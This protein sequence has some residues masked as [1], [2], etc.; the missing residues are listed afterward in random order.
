MGWRVPP[1]S[2][3]PSSS[4]LSFKNMMISFQTTKNY[5]KS[6]TSL[7]KIP[8]NCVIIGG[9]LPSGCTRDWNFTLF[10][11]VLSGANTSAVS[12]MIWWRILEKYVF[13]RLKMKYRPLISDTYSCVYPVEFCAFSSPGPFLYC[14]LDNAPKFSGFEESSRRH[15]GQFWIPLSDYLYKSHVWCLQTKHYVL[16]ISLTQK[17]SRWS[18]ITAD[19]VTLIWQCHFFG[20][21]EDARELPK[22]AQDEHRT[23]FLIYESIRKYR[24][25]NRP[26]PYVPRGVSL[27]CI[28]HGLHYCRVWYINW[29]IMVEYWLKIF[30][31]WIYPITAMS[32]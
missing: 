17:V 12:L 10:T 25:M 28:D 9:I 31:W 7:F 29:V 4:N 15:L 22:C 5:W 32:F 6:A 11:Q 21:H 30:Q 13:L 14:L 8:S 16:G 3:S 26:K 23:P 18:L 24:Q 27:Q 20:C 19:S 2:I 1:W